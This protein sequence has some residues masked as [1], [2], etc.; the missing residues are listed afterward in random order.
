MKVL[1]IEDEDILSKVLKDMFEDGGWKV[2]VASDGVD[3]LEA[4]KEDSFDVVLLDLLLPKKNGFE[5]LGEIRAD[6]TH[7][8][9]PVLIISNLGGRDE[10]REAMRLGAT[11][12]FIKTQHSLKDI[13]EK[14]SDYLS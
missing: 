6:A 12:Y 1:I 7:R 13:L 2:R 8:D 10:I 5:V 11:D 9:L 4:L 3:G 14:A